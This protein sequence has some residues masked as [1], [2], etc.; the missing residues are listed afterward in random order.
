[1]VEGVGGIC[2]NLESDSFGKLKSLTQTK[3]QIA[4]IR[5]DQC[6]PSLVAEGAGSRCHECGIVIPWAHVG[7]ESAVMSNIWIPNNIRQPLISAT[8]LVLSRAAQV[9]A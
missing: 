2:P 9:L 3:I 8:A 6:I 5:T 7:I 4:P 1:M